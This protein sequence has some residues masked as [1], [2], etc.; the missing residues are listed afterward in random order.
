[1]PVRT[2]TLP[3]MK[4]ARPAV[5]TTDKAKAKPL[6]FKRLMM[7]RRGLSLGASWR[8]RWACGSAMW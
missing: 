5:P 6:T 1:M 8:A 7:R 4:A 3:L 2:G